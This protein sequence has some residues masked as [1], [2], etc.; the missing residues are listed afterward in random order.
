MKFMPVV[1]SFVLFAGYLVMY[2][3]L[4]SGAL[5]NPYRIWVSEYFSNLLL[6][7]QV[8][9]IVKY[10]FMAKKS[11]NSWNKIVLNCF[12]ISIAYVSMDLFIHTT[13]ARFNP[14]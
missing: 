14:V 8:I 3:L 9:S 7:V 11:G 13:V 2:L 6:I 4:E 1:I 12:I 10:A 5:H